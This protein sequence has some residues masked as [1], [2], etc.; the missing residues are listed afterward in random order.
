MEN[1][2]LIIGKIIKQV[3]YDENGEEDKIIL[4]FDDNTSAVITSDASN[5]MY[6]LFIEENKTT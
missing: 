4:F 2:E 1:D 3:K 6:S 5:F